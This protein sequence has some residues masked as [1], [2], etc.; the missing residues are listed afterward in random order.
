MISILLP[1]YGLAMDYKILIIDD[2][3]V[4]RDFLYEVLSDYGYKVEL[5]VDGIEGVKKV[6][7][8]DY[9]LI[10]CDV[11]MPIKNGL[12]TVKEILEIRPGLP[13]VM[14]DSYPGKLAEAAQEA[15]ALFCLSKPF[16]LDELKETVTNLLENKTTPVK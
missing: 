6:A 16:S 7:E 13:I 15:G 9:N 12:N 8:N 10:F 11:H 4:I 3:Q 2:T 1:H 14:T 5:A